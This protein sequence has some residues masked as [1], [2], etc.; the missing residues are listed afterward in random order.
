MKHLRFVLQIALILSVGAGT[1]LRAAEPVASG[2][3]GIEYST[4]EEALKALRAKPGVTFK[5]QDGWLV[6]ND[7]NAI[8][9]W[10]FTPAGHPAYPSMIKRHIVNGPGGAYMDTA[11]RCLASQVVCDRIFGDKK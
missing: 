5:D 6:A 1:T 8:V 7:S 9:I 11:I 3:T 2:E 10:L 4:L